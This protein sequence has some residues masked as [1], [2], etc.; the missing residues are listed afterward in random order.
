[1]PIRKYRST[2]EISAHGTISGQNTDNMISSLYINRIMHAFFHIK[3][4]IIPQPI[5]ITH[6]LVCVCVCVCEVN[7]VLFNSMLKYVINRLMHAFFH[8]RAVIIPRPRRYQRVIRSWKSKKVKQHNGQEKKNKKWSTKHHAE[9]LKMEQH[10]PLNIGVNSIIVSNKSNWTQSSLVSKLRM[11]SKTV[12]WTQWCL[13]LKFE[14]S[15]LYSK[16]F[17]PV[18]FK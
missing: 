17:F 10:A 8:I 12:M 11:L 13:F 4:V 15:Q 9:P 14:W 7:F 6:S 18:F 3:T 1:M 2:T 16:L 5:S